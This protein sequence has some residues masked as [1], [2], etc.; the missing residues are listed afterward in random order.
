MTLENA[1]K[2]CCLYW[3]QTLFAISMSRYRKWSIIRYIDTILELIL[4]IVRLHAPSLR[5]DPGSSTRAPVAWPWWSCDRSAQCKLGLAPSTP[6]PTTN[7]CANAD[8]ALILR[9]KGDPFPTGGRSVPIICQNNP[10]V[11]GVYKIILMLPTESEPPRSQKEEM[12]TG[13]VEPA[14]ERVASGN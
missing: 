12:D 1:Q 14:P 10:E 4:N 13:W 9:L 11:R 8:F 5:G 6:L 7:K 3:F 2:T